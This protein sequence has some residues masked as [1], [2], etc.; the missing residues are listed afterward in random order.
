MSK[1]RHNTTRRQQRRLDER[2]A[3]REETLARHGLPIQYAP[4]ETPEWFGHGASLRS[5]R[6]LQFRAYFTKSRS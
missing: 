4:S 2:M 5:S 3:R 1:G 6:R